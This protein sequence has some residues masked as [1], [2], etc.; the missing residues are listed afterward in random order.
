[1]QPAQY[2]TAPAAFLDRCTKSHECNEIGLL[3]HGIALPWAS[4]SDQSRKQDW[5]MGGCPHV[6]LL[7]Y[8]ED[9]WTKGL[10]SQDLTRW[11]FLF[12]FFLLK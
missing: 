9:T 10:E 7:E 12:V 4:L 5:S 3:E 1:M 8:S 11:F 2:P 6:Q